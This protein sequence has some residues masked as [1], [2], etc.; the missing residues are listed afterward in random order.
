MI[1]ALASDRVTAYSFLFATFAIL[2]LPFASVFLSAKLRARLG[3]RRV[4]VSL[5]ALLVV[6]PAAL[7]VI[8]P[9]LIESP[10]IRFMERDER[11]YGSLANACD[12]VLA[13]HPLGTNQPLRIAG[14]DVSLPEIIRDLRPSSVTVSSNRV[15]IMA[16]VRLFGVSWEPQEDGKT[17]VWSLIVYPEGPQSVVYVKT[18]R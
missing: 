9:K 17:N 11:Y 8:V 13:E 4:V 3:V 14:S 7:A 15:H 6:V 2:V 10:F 12:A 1:A 16:G 18:N 5:V